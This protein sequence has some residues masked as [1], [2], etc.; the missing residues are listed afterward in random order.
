MR[1]KRKI[2]YI[3]KDFQF[4]F[5]LKFCAVVIIGSIIST[6][7][8]YYTSQDTITSTFNNSRLALRTTSQVILPAVLYTNLFTLIMVGVAS[9]FVTLYISHKIA[10]PLYRLEEDLKMVSSGDLTKNFRLRDK[11]QLSDLAGSLNAFIKSLDGKVGGVQGK[12]DE[13]LENAPADCDKE[14]YVQALESLRGY[15][16]AEFKTSRGKESR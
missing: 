6:L 16:D 14:Q 1:P 3:K 9:T 7:I 12:I 8:L 10:G 15:I 13:M 2:L 11:D 5:I 4:K